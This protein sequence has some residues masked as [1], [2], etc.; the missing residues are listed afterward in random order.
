MNTL[1]K[2]LVQDLKLEALPPEE[3]MAV[4]E[5]FSDLVFQGALIRGM[6]MLNDKQKDE[7][8]AKLD[9]AE[10]MGP[11]IMMDALMEMIPD[12]QKVIDE[13]TE[14]ILARAKRTIAP[15]HG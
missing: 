4:V 14:R 8:D 13:E 2:R 11:D 12:F 7:L 6:E 15:D 9:A 10:Q 1:G 3:Q 5:R